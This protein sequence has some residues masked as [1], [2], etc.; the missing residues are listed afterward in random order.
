MGGAMKN[1]I[2]FIL[3]LLISLISCKDEPTAPEETTP[4]EQALTEKTIG[5]E[6]GTLETEDFKLIVPSGAFTNNEILKLF[7]LDSTLAGNNIS[8]TFRLEGLPQYFNQPLEMSIKYRGIL[9]G[10]V[11]IERALEAEVQ[12]VDSSFTDIVF[13]L[14][15][16]TEKDG[17]ITTEFSPVVPTTSGYYKLNRTNSESRNWDISVKNGCSEIVSYNFVLRSTNFKFTDN[18]ALYNKITNYLEAAVSRFRNL[19]FDIPELNHY[20]CT[21]YPTKPN[22]PDFELI[23]DFLGSSLFIRMKENVDVDNFRDFF[24]YT[25]AVLYLKGY[26]SIYPDWPLEGICQWARYEYK[27]G[28]IRNEIN[29]SFHKSLSSQICSACKE[30]D[31]LASMIEYLVDTYGTP[32][33]SKIVDDM[34]KNSEDGLTALQKYTAPVDNWLTEYYLYLMTSSKWQNR[35]N[36]VTVA[37]PDFWTNKKHS[38][39]IIDGGTTEVQWNDKFDDMSAKLYRIQLASNLNDNSI[40]NIKLEASNAKLSLL[41]LNGNQFDF[42]NTVNDNLSIS[43]LKQLANEGTELFLLVVNGLVN[44]PNYGTSD[45]K[46]T[47]EQIQAPIITSCSIHLVDIDVNIRKYWDDGT[48]TDDV[49]E[50]FWFSFNTQGDPAPIP[51]FENN[52]FY[53]AYSFTDNQGYIVSGNMSIQFSKNIDTV[54]SFSAEY[55]IDK[56][57]VNPIYGTL[58]KSISGHDIPLFSSNEFKVTGLEVCEKLYN[59]LKNSA[60]G[61]GSVDWDILSIKECRSDND[62]WPSSLSIKITKQ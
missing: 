53:Q 58:E 16:T 38:E 37:D 24:D 28:E 31:G 46:L 18:P 42:V 30:S 47:I 27:N 39:T 45:L 10:H 62:Q 26:E 13:D 22:K 1:F 9:N 23:T 44:Y 50:R 61:G 6:G 29:D 48:Y 5:P 32:I 36:A 52:V 56:T 11:F 55:K 8:P 54:L 2:P 25:F 34:G 43:N 33:L 4:T 21:I 20:V 49:Y 51:T 19:N 14:F 15:N 59:N 35:L 17:F 3:I 12:S 57:F 40:L 60:T 41:K 7:L